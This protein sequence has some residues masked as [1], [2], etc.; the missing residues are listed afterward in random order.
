MRSANCCR[1]SGR[2]PESRKVSS[3][4]AYNEGF[5]WLDV[6]KTNSNAQRFY[7]SFG[8]GA[9][10]EIPFSTDMAE[11]GMIVMCRDLSR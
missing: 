10:G 11:I 5:I 9:L 8:F 3:A 4:Y 7:E 6:L 1:I 2:L